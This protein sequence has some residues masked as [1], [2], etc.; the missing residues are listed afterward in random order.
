MSTEPEEVGMEPPKYLGDPNPAVKVT[1]LFEQGN[2]L[3]WKLE[4]PWDQAA[5]FMEIG[6]LARKYDLGIE[7][8]FPVG[9][10]DPNTHHP[11][12]QCKAHGDYNCPEDECLTKDEPEEKPRP[13]DAQ[14]IARALKQKCPECGREFDLLDETDAAEWA[15]GHDCEVGGDPDGGP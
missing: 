6:L 8:E 3:V 13:T 2:G 11:D 14:I 1:I 15:Y 5:L 10:E 12:G 9:D 4:K 7:F